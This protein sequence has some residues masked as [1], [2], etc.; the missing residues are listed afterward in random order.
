MCLLGSCSLPQASLSSPYQRQ[1]AVLHGP[2]FWAG[3]CVGICVRS[4]MFSVLYHSIWN[5][6][7]ILGRCSAA[8]LKEHSV[9]VGARCRESRLMSY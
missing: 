2:C 7:F 8:G 9:K 1:E 4:K 3:F 5:L 6:V